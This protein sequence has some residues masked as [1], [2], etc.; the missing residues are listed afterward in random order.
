MYEDDPWSRAAGILRWDQHV[1]GL[2]DVFR[3]VLVTLDVLEDA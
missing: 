2:K 1:V 3:C